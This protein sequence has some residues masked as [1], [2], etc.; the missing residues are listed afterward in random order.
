M[1]Q[2]TSFVACVNNLE[3]VGKASSRSSGAEVTLT[4]SGIND[5]ATYTVQRSTTTGGPYSTVGSKIT[6][7]AFVDQTAGL[8]NGD[9]YFYVL[10]PVNSGGSAVCTSNQASVKI[11]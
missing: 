2:K 9:T 11:P 7:L 4:W 3:G 6:G 10:Q 5:A 1:L 8:V